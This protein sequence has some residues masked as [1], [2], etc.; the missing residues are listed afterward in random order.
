M[1]GMTNNFILDIDLD[2]PFGDIRIHY[3]DDDE[4]NDDNDQ[5]SLFSTVDYIYI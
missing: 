5:V 1:S 2:T 3:D 4:K